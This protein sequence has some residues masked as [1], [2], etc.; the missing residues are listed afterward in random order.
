MTEGQY[1]IV[2]PNQWFRHLGIWKKIADAK[3]SSIIR[4]TELEERQYMFAAHP[5]GVL[6]LGICLNVGTNGTNLE[7]LFPGIAFR[8][9]AVSACYVI[10]FYRDMCLA[11]GGTDC[12]ASTIHAL[13]DNGISPVV[14]PGG[15]DESVLTINHHNNGDNSK[16]LTKQNTD[17]PNSSFFFIQGYTS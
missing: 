8:G 15:A 3:H 12:R 9:V 11:V 17:Q 13:L 4:T 16:N 6:P 5:H 2:R 14:V 1:F 7:G 10:P